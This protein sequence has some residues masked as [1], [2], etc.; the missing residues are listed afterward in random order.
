MEVEEADQGRLVWPHRAKERLNV[1]A[2]LLGRFW[3]WGDQHFR[4][5]LRVFQTLPSARELAPVVGEGRGQHAPE[6]A[7]NALWIPQLSCMFQRPQ[8]EALKD[9]IGGLAIT[10]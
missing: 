4:E 6:P 2:G 8:R 5:L 7:A 10:I 1:V 9:V 3:L